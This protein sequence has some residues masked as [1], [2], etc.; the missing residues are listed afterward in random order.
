MKMISNEFAF[1]TLSK[2]EIYNDR[3]TALALCFQH[4]FWGGVGVLSLFIGIE[5]VVAYITP[6]SVW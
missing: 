1:A 3:E 4:I 2:Y 5:M 6:S